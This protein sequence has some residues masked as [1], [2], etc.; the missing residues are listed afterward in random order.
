GDGRDL[1]NWHCAG[2][3]PRKGAIM[4]SPF[5][6]MDPYLE[7]PA[8]WPDVHHNL[9]TEIQAALNTRIRPR[10]VARVDMRVYV[11]DENDPA[12]EDFV[13]D[14]RVDVTPKQR[15]SRKPKVESMPV[16]TEP[17]IV[18]TLMDEEVEEAF[19]K[20]VQVDSEDLVTVI[21][22]LS[23]TNKI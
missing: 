10:Y 20:I 7:T 13:P 23:P 8:L 2:T 1:A 4:P 3:S 18:P 5:P 17:V 14:V 16:V 15:G 6:G 12:R 22:V 19:L 21:E 9:I 11:S